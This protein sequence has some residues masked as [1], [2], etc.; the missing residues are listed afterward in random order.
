VPTWESTSPY[1]DEPRVAF[2]WTATAALTAAHVI[3]FV[4]CGLAPDAADVLMLQTQ[5]AVGR[6]WAWQ[7]VTYGF[8]QTLNREGLVWF[9]LFTLMLWQF[10][11][12]LESHV[13]ARRLL[14]IYFAGLAYGG[15]VQCAYLYSVQSVARTSGFLY[16]GFFAVLMT[17]AL[18]FPRQP[19]RFFFLF[20]MKLIH[21]TL[22][23][24]ALDVY[25]CIKDFRTGAAPFAS[26]GAAATAWAI[27][28]INPA[29]D[30]WFFGRRFKVDELLDK[31]SREG[32]GSLTKEE[33]RFLEK[34]GRVS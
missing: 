20:P 9:L 32:I 23:L 4:L 31:I 26:V 28:K 11:R 15:L 34:A 16:P 17:L 10:G 1:I 22:I 13:G 30:R 33:R 6:L 19:I 2:Q 24:M 27:F 29:I 12:Q 8:T 3:G 25:F 14:M 5:D 7:F 18:S 21:S